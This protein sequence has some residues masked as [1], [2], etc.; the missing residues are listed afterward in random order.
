MDKHYSDTDEQWRPVVGYED[1]Y[2]VSSMGNVRSSATGQGRQRR[3]LRPT[4][5]RW[6]Y[7]HTALSR[8][9]NRRGY[10]VHCLVAE[11]FI[12]NPEH[13]SQVNHI[14]GNKC[15]NSVSNLEWCTAKENTAHAL[16]LG[17]APHAKGERH[18][19]AKLNTTQVI[20]IRHCRGSATCRRLAELYGVSNGTI[21]SIWTRRTWSHV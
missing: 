20:N 11:A 2:E 21:C 17:L 7:C 3:Q 6:G 18:G 15:N 10:F 4:V 16:R 12:P 5:T 14:D 13:K 19:K 9:D 1:L 8:N